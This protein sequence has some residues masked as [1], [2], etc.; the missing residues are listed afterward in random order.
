VH[1]VGDQLEA[2]LSLIGFVT[3]GLAVQHVAGRVHQAGQGGQSI[4]DHDYKS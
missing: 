1:Q 3:R 2:E 4:T